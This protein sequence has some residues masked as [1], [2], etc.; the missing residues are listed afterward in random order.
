MP[1]PRSPR[2]ATSAFLLLC[3][4]AVTLAVGYIA[5]TRTPPSPVAS[6]SATTGPLS[7]QSSADLLSKPYVFF[8]DTSLGELHGRVILESQDSSQRAPTKMSCERVDFAGG[9]GV[10]L[11]AEMRGFKTEYEAHV[12]DAS[13]ERTHD[14]IPLAGVPSRVR[15]S[16]D[17]VRAGITVF[18]S[19]DSYAPGT[20][21][22]R[23]TVIDTTTGQMLGDLEQ[24][25]ILRD[26]IPF[27]AID[28]NF[29]GL[30]FADRAHAYATLG[31]GGQ[32]F[33]VELDIDAKQGKVIHSSVECPSLSPD[34]THIAFKRRTSAGGRLL[35]RLYVLDLKDG[36]ETALAETRT[37]DDQPEWRN[38]ASVAYGLPSDTKPGSTDVWAVPADGSGAPVRVLQAAWSPAFGGETK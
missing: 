8:R 23:T 31:T 13:L 4:A 29:W 5:W 2:S 20:F 21:S 15:V 27:K 35:W 3:A 19:G 22:T 28:F 1:P 16:P 9:Y 32:T 12:F 34:K 24:F 37:V 30:T 11:K 10:C 7:P 36:R 18:V 6:T 17:G 25:T 38:S 26:G 33:L 14:P